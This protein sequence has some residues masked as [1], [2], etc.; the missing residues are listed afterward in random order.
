MA[1]EIPLDPELPAYEFTIDLDG[2][3]YRLGFAWNARA[4]AWSM[5][6]G[7]EAGEPLV[8]GLKVVANW[9]LLDRYADPRLPPGVLMSVDTSG[10][11]IDPGRDDLGDRV[12]IVYLE[13]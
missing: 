11:G 9:P 1:L 12:R 13:A 10:D 8:M 6:L 2:R 5:D 4:G 7:T 3:V